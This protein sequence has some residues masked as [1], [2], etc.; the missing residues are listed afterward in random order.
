M[1]GIKEYE[2]YLIAEELAEASIEKYLADAGELIEYM[3]DREYNK[4]SL[5]AYKDYLLSEEANDGRGYTPS[6]VNSKIISTNKY[7]KWQGLDDLTIKTVKMQARTLDDTM[8][9]NDFERLRRVALRQGKTQDVLILDIFYYTGIRVSELE[10][11]TL[12]ACKKGYMTVDNK[13]KIRRVPI[14]KKLAKAGKEYAKANGIKAGAIIINPNTN[15]PLSR[16]TIFNRLKTMA[17]QSR[18]KKS[19][20]HP[21]ALRHLFAKQWIKAN[22]KNPLDLAD[23]MG[24]E[25][26]ETTRIYTRLNIEE[27]KN[28]ITF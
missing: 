2:A 21:H 19:K 12:E 14:I 17:G 9:Q 24:H 23:I 26:L 10:F 20:I 18:V 13:G 4:T 11:F 27:L 3:K 7:L 6:S 25:S 1:K 22:G 15:K 8:T 28:T 16:T 5:I